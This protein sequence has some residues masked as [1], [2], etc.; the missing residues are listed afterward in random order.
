MRQEA[1]TFPHGVLTELIYRKAS[2]YRR[3]NLF[4]MSAIMTRCSKTGRPVKTGITTHMV[5]FSSLP[6]VAIPMR[7][8]LCG[9]GHR[10]KPSDAWIEGEINHDPLPGEVVQGGAELRRTSIPLSTIHH[11]R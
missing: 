4:F 6:D 11:R 7:C 9:G 3:V 8:P 2:R 1:R 5:H 10:W